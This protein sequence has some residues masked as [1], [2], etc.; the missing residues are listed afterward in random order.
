LERLTYL[1]YRLGSSLAVPLAPALKN[2]A[3]LKSTSNSMVVLP[4]SLLGLPALG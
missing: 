3:A 4:L 1:K 2:S